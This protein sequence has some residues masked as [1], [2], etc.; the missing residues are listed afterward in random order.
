MKNLFT[1]LL[2]IGFAFSY[3]QTYNVNVTKTPSFSESFNNAYRNATA[4][5]AARAA[6]GAAQSAAAANNYKEIGTDFLIGNTSNFR[7]II[8]SKVTGWKPK[9]NRETI[10]NELSSTGK[11][12][13]VNP[14]KPKKNYDGIPSS[15]MN[16]PQ[17]LFLEWHREAQNQYDRISNLKVKDY[18]GNIIFEAD[19]KNL[20]YS[21]M[22]KPLMSEYNYSKDVAIELIKE[23]KELK[24]LEVISQE[25]YNEL[26]NKLKPIILGN[27]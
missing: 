24:D 26:V 17:T 15:F 12:I 2:L 22:L 18:K 7:A 6:R 3:S 27:N 23:Y 14:E 13:I 19:Y 10:F 20:G 9:D 16:S 8:I 4:A 11:Y 25:E 21:E 1:L 5:S